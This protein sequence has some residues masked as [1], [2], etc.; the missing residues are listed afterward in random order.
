MFYIKVIFL[1]NQ[2]YNV[3]LMNID[4]ETS[5]LDLKFLIS[6]FIGIPECQQK[7]YHEKIILDNDKILEN[8]NI[9]KSSTILLER[10]TVIKE[11]I[12]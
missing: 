2:Q 10:R 5:I 11:L 8:Y 4:S 1:E 9:I 7:I 12:S 6:T 3:V